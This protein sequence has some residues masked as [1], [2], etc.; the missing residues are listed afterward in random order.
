MKLSK[1]LRVFSCDPAV[2][3][4]SLLIFMERAVARVQALVR[5]SRQS[6]RHPALHLVLP[7]PYF[8]ELACDARALL[9][10]LPDG[11]E[12]PVPQRSRRDRVRPPGTLR[13]HGLSAWT[14]GQRNSPWGKNCGRDEHLGLN[15]FRPT[16]PPCTV[17]GRSKG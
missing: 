2:R 5:A 11:Q 7:A 14:Q 17:S 6:S 1:H 15:H 16:L 13:W 10:R 8:C 4:E 3:G 9:S 12:N